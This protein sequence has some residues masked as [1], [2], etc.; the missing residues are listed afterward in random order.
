MGAID[1]LI[2]LHFFKTKKVPNNSH[3]WYY[4]CKA[5]SK[6]IQH[7]DN[8]L[9]R[10]LKACPNTDHTTRN[11]A[12][13]RLMAKANIDMMVHQLGGSND[14]SNSVAGESDSVTS[15]ASISV[16]SNAS[17]SVTGDASK[18]RKL[19]SSGSLAGF[20]DV[21]LSPAVKDLADIKWFRYVPLISAGQHRLMNVSQIYC[22]Q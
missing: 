7:C 15:N 19:D 16:T 14:A 22:P 13:A 6:E 5:C 20:M 3:R 4:Q 10:H 12:N 11:L 2:G 1:P 17:I 21:P 18:K 9:L 8:E